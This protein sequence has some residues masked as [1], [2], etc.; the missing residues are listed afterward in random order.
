MKRT[1]SGMHAYSKMIG[2]VLP[3]KTDTYTPIAHSNVI[4]RVRSEITNAGFIITG[5]EYRCS[6]DA[7]V[8]VGTFRMN[9][10]S[11]PDIELSANFL[12]SYN[13]Q[14][15]FRFNLGGL[16]KVCNNGM[17]LNNNKFGAY[18]RVHKGAADLLAEGKIGEFIKDSELYW[19]N[20]VEHKDKMKDVLL[21]STAQHDLLG[22]LFFK[23]KILNTM[24]L[25][26]IR[27]ELE[28]PSFEYKVDSDSAW[29]LYNHIT[30]SLKDSHPS[31]WMDDQVAVHEVFANM[32]GLEHNFDE[33]TEAISVV[34]TEPSVFEVK[35]E[36]EVY[37]ITPF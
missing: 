13:K 21:T 33:E 28:K 26:Q 25:N 6:N 12:N 34:E 31:T 18:K 17:M 29:A 16:V 2:A 24:Q 22:E 36:E 14:Y 3:A 8:A 10:K 35:V 37:D 23:K 7:Q 20:L 1:M 5:E 4:N 30:L 15:A 32:L 27:T 9:Y 19:E 11:D